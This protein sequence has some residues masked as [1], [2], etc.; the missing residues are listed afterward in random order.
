MSDDENYLYAMKL[1][2]KILAKREYSRRLLLDKLLKK[3][4]DFDVCEQVL[5]ELESKSFLSDQRFSDAFVRDAVIKLRGPVRIT[6]ELEQK[7]VERDVITDALSQITDWQAI[8]LSSA[9]KKVSYEAALDCFESEQLEFLMAENKKK[10]MSHLSYQ[11]FNYDMCESV[12]KCLE[13]DYCA[14]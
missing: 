12:A 5:N 2:L 3:S 1:A 6:S 7:G 13:R 8:A 10:V 9:K 4:C 14:Y 11:G